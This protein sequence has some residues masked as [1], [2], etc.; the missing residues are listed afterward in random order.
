MMIFINVDI[1]SRRGAKNVGK[2]LNCEEINVVFG[3]TA[4][5]FLPLVDLLLS[6]KGCTFHAM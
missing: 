6:T 1:Y 4:P 5:H 2:E 3:N